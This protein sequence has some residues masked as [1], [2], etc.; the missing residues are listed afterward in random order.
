MDKKIYK[1][2]GRI[3]IQMQVQTEMDKEKDREKIHN[4]DKAGSKDM[5]SVIN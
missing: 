4:Q 5:S 2:K 1:K 3:K